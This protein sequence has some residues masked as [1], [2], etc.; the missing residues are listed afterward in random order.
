MFAGDYNVNVTGLTE[1][2]LTGSVKVENEKVAKVEV[3]SDLA[4]LTGSTTAAVGYKVYN[5]Y[6]EDITS[7]TTINATPSS[8]SA[9]VDAA[10][11]VI[12]ITGLTT[13]KSGDKL[14]LT[15]VHTE[16]ATAVSKV[17]TVSDAAKVSEVTVEGLYN[18][19][20]KELSEDNRA[21]DFYLLINAKDQYGNALSAS[22]LNSSNVVVNSSNPLV[23]N[24][25][26]SDFKEITVDGK[27]RIALDLNT[28]A[29]TAGKATFSI[30]TLASAKVTSFEVEVKEAAKVDSL[31]ISQPELAVAKEKVVLPVE[32]FDKQG[33]TVTKQE[34]LDATQLTSTA[35]SVSFVKNA[36]TGKSELVLDLTGVTS[37]TKVTVTA[38]TPTQKVV[39][40]V[41]DVKEAAKAVYISGVKDITT[42]VQQGENFE[43]ALKNIVVKDQYERDFKLTSTNLG[44]TN[45]L[46]S[47]EASIN[48][49]TSVID[50]D[51]AQNLIDGTT[52]KIVVDGIAKGTDT[53]KLTVNEYKTVG[54]TA[55]TKVP[56]A[57]SDFDIQSRVTASSE[58]SSYEVASIDALYDDN[59]VDNVAAADTYTSDVVVYGV[60][61]NG[62]K[63]K[64][65]SS[66]YTLTTNTNGVEVAG[67]TLNIEAGTIGTSDVAYAK[68]ATEAKGALTV[69][70]NATGE[71]LSKEFT[72]TQAKPKVSSVVFDTALVSGGAATVADTANAIAA[73]DLFA[74]AT[75]ATVTDQYGETVTINSTTGAIAFTDTTVTANSSIVISEYASVGTANHTIT[76]N[77]TGSVAI[78]AG[79]ENTES[80]KATFNFGGHQV[81]VKVVVR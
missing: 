1:A 38:I 12:N 70:I 52:D 65:P 27:K 55:N 39:N 40:L 51:T 58:Y 78:T 29:A 47:I 67:S 37:A 19:D 28:S 10:K 4:V 25:T 6:N 43:I 13:P 23:A 9:S 54:G 81:P 62:Q 72:I 26:S 63:V 53:L 11:G 16:T 32:A 79:A 50:F 5:Q 30:I 76:G 69:T 36:S 66:A 60:L 15:L 56:V 46:Y 75:G 17:L 24:A 33:N 20:K 64:L 2:A 8:G 45:G 49:G 35:G 68:D 61:A 34:L 48:G 14:S 18:A 71:Q 31:V 80:F 77:G 21:S 59:G 7:K 57:G 3:A 42:N 22:D 44:T 74:L 73:G 41:V